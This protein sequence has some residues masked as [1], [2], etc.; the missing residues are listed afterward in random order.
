MDNNMG[1]P[2]IYKSNIDGILND[3]AWKLKDLEG[4]TAET[5]RVLNIKESKKDSERAKEELKQG[6]ISKLSPEELEAIGLAPRPPEETEE[7][8]QQI[9]KKIQH[10]EVGEM[11]IELLRREDGNDVMDWT[12][13]KEDEG[14]LALL[15]TKTI[16]GKDYHVCEL[17]TEDTPEARKKFEGTASGAFSRTEADLRRVINDL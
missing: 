5:E 3:M 13:I 14:N 12:K 4:R 8:N 7:L 15:A 16:D 9:P 10:L 11:K 1:P 6:A 2:D 17:V